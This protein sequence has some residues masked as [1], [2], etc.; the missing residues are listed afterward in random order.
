MCTTRQ[1]VLTS[2]RVL[3]EAMQGW[4]WYGQLTCS[5]RL[6]Y[7]RG[8]APVVAAYSTCAPPVAAHPHPPPGVL[9][10]TL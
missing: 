8:P 4:E 6:R 10:V 5:L 7:R 1:A 3:T 9:C 2:L